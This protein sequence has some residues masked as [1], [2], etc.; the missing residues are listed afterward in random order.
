MERRRICSTIN[1]ENEMS[2]RAR[3]RERKRDGFYIVLQVKGG[4]QHRFF[5]FDPCSFMGAIMINTRRRVFRRVLPKS[6]NT[7]SSV[8]AR[9]CR[10]RRPRLRPSARPSDD[11]AGSYR[12][13]WT[14]YIQQARRKELVPGPVLRSFRKSPVKVKVQIYYLSHLSEAQCKRRSWDQKEREVCD[15]F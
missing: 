9:K 12:S 7:D 3:K 8:L 5:W 6:P 2:A 11:P 15:A 14:V 1:R 10:K 4:V 13:D